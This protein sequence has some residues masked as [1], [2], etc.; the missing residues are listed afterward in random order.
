MKKRVERA[1]SPAMPEKLYEHIK[2]VRKN[3]ALRLKMAAKK[4]SELPVQWQALT[5]HNNFEE[6]SVDVIRPSPPN[7]DGMYHI[8]VGIDG[9]SQFCFGAPWVDTSGML[10]AKIIYCLSWT[11]GY[12]SACQW[13]NARQSDSRLVKC[14]MELARADIHASI[15]FNMQSNGKI[16]RVIR[17]IILH[18][19]FVVN[20]RKIRD[21][22][23]TALASATRIVNSGDCQGSIGL[24]LFKIM[25]LGRDISSHMY[26]TTMLES[27]SKYSKNE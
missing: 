14:S 15:P 24:S 18:L 8:I 21:Q 5:L 22:W 26:P 11:F 19:K 23:D 1:K 12:T 7:A 16:Q 6:L 13:D 4:N 9:F 2:Y 27:I 25:F 10:A 17:V 3:C 20:D